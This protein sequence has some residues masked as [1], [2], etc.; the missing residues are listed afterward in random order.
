M[1]TDPTIAQTRPGAKWQP[2][3]GSEARGLIARKLPNETPQAQEAMLESA[4]SILS[5]GIPPTAA[6]GS[7]TG[8][9]VG[10]VQSG[11]TLS[12]TTVIAL[13][14]D[15][16]F[17]L[18]VV[19]AGTSAPLLDQSTRRL[20]RD[21]RIDEFEGQL[22]WKFFTNPIRWTDNERRHI[23][24]TLA[25]WQDPDV[26]PNER[27]TV[28]ISVM[29]QHRHLRALVNLL[30]NL[31]L[32]GIPTLI[33]DD[34]ADQASLNTMVTRSQ[35]S[36]TYRRLLELRDTMPNHTFLQYTA[37]PQ[38]PLLI[39]IIDTLSPN[40]VEVLEPG[41]DYTGGR[42]FFQDGLDLIKVIDPQD[43]STD[44]NPLDAPP[45]LLLEALRIFL[46][47]VAA[48]QLEGRS[49]RNPNRSMLVHPS[50]R[51][52]SHRE[53]RRWIGEVFDEWQRILAL[54]QEDADRLDLIETFLNAHS[55]LASTVP[56]VPPFE[57]LSR[58]LTRAFRNT[59]IEEVNARGRQTPI[60]DWI[61]SY[62]W[63][64]VGGQAMD[65]GF[66]VEGLTVTYMP[67]GPGVGNADTIQQ[68]GRFFGYKKR[69]LGYCRAYLELDAF[70]AFVEYVE[71][72]EFMRRQLQEIQ[73]SGQALDE[74]KRAFVL[75]SDLQPCR[76]NVL[77]QDLARGDYG[78]RWFYPS[79]ALAP[80]EVLDNNRT[81]IRDFM[82]SVEFKVDPNSTGRDKAQRHNL[83]AGLSLAE[84][85]SD[86]VVP[87][88]VTG[89]GD[90]RELIGIML[91]LSEAL[92]ENPTELCNVYQMRPGYVADRAIDADGRVEQLFQGPTPLASGGYGYPGDR[93][94]HDPD[95]V[96]FQLHSLNLKQGDV[97][98]REVPMIAIRL[99]QRFSLEWVAQH[100]QN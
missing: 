63:I 70:N 92:R 59:R 25:E 81:V 97:V 80:N 42:A 95:V 93:A 33:I 69:Y 57:E 58:R 32:Q 79:T 44:D 89:A 26:E 37:T 9:V 18:V 75:S 48:G 53:Y 30:R 73:R 5:K 36:T 2:L 99:P 3:I 38:A 31:E 60:I 72:E 96:A 50:Q 27:A 16:G 61:Q 4:A 77:D 20:R 11:K 39:N 47:G 43:I 52:D 51:T 74:W 28:L 86:L 14:R 91:Q 1:S 21:L 90:T 41:E 29:K 62:G 49:A 8:L 12:F 98:A 45:E 68:R 34:E 94:F 85:I 83:A 64:L 78:G 15:N 10:Y 54:P 35:Q 67:R 84:V 6:L 55:D 22:N 23:Q 56:D 66:T 17:Q 76:K 82:S 46:L 65:R 88:R 87:F 13:A 100:Q 71:H 19:V 40:F 24:Q 7:E